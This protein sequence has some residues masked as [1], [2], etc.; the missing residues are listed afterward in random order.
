MTNPKRILL[1]PAGLPQKEAFL[2]ARRQGLHIV[3]VD[4]DADAELKALADE[5]YHVNPGDDDAFTAFVSGY[6]RQYPLSGV[7]VVG[8]DLP[9]SCARA[10]ALTGTPAIDVAAAML[11][12]DKL[13]MKQTMAAAG[14]A[15]PP[16]QAVSDAGQLAQLVRSEAGRWVVKPND[17]CGSRGV[18][19]IDSGDDLADAF[20]YARRHSKRDNQVIVER[21]VAGPQISIEAIVMDGQVHVTGFADRN[22]EF[23]ASLAPHIIENGATMPTLLS[24][25]E[26]RAVEAMFS[27]GVTA[28]GLDQCVAK[29]DMVL[30]PDGPVVIEIAGR[31]SGGKFASKLVPEATGVNLLEAAIKLAVGETVAPATLRQRYNR[32]VAVR[33]L[34]P[35]PGTV[36]S[37]TGVEE[38][39]AMAGIIEVVVN[40]RVG[41]DIVTITNHAQRGG[42]VVATAECRADAVARA[43]AAVAAIRIDSR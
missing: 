29:G 8:C 43:E 33:Y 4:G 13:K 15:V 3:S 23:L 12:V 5:F 2:E 34:F 22:Y 40:A 18:L 35:R 37:V 38:A 6:H 26:R 41:D 19:Q 27:R 14:V 32:G 25:E 10:A 16:F 11:T 17:N 20:E 30:G 7:L 36:V 24:T 28:L 21:F 42:W 1:Y 9:V 39:R 31:I